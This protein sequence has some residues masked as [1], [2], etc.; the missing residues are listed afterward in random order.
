MRGAIAGDVIGSRFEHF[1]FKYK[2]FPLFSRISRPTDDTVMTVAVAE[3][4]LGD[5]DYREAFRR[6]GHRYPRA[7][8]GGTFRKWLALPDEEAGPYG[9]FGNGSAMRVSPVGWL[10]HSVEEILAEAERTALPTHNHPE[11]IKGAQAIALAVF[12]ARTGAGKDMIRSEI[13]GRF[14]YDLGRQLDAIRPVYRPDVTCQGSVP[15]ALI[16]FLESTD[17]EDAV[18]NAVSLGG[19]SDTQACMAGAVAEAFYGGVPAEIRAEVEGRLP[20]D[21]REV[22][23]RFDAV[24]EQGS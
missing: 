20:A 11:G 16:A 24:R 4:M 19:D 6:W 15:E 17:W 18:R 9:S 13:E 14:G 2:E 10:R 12:L 22:L 8:Y 3:A 23:G 21:M 5:G 1:P 7:G